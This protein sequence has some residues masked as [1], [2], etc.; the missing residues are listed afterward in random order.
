MQDAMI[1]FPVFAG[2]LFPVFVPV[3]SAT[4]GAVA[5]RVRPPVESPVEQTV[6]RIKERSAAARRAEAVL[7]QD[8]PATTTAH[9]PARDQQLYRRA[10]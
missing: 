8:A 6:S 2:M 1:V 7:A 4:V 9:G 3:I 10:A 5:D